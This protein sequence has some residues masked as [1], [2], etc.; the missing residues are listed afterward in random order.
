MAVIQRSGKVKTQ[1]SSPITLSLANPIDPAHSLVVLITS[2]SGASAQTFSG[3]CGG[4]ALAVATSGNHPNNVGA[5]AVLFLVDPLSGQS[6]VTVSAT[7]HAGY[8]TAA[9]LEVPKI[10]GAAP[11][12]RQSAITTATIASSGGDGTITPDAGTTTVAKALAVTLWGASGATATTLGSAAAPSGYDL[13]F[14]END[15]VNLQCGAGASS[16]LTSAQAVAPTW[17]VT[18]SAGA[19]QP[20]SLVG[21]TVVFELADQGGGTP[22]PDLSMGFS[23]I[24]PPDVLALSCSVLSAPAMRTLAAALLEAY[25]A[26]A[27]ACTVQSGGPINPVLSVQHAYKLWHGAGW[28]PSSVDVTVAAGESVLVLCAGWNSQGA[29]MVP[30]M[31]G[32]GLTAILDQGTNYGSYGYPVYCQ[33]YA[34]FGLSAG[35]Y[36]VSP[37]GYSTSADDGDMWVI[38]LAAG[39]SLRAGSA[40]QMHDEG[41]GFVSASL[42]LGAGAQIG[43]A[44]FGICVTDNWTTTTT[45]D[46]IEQT[47]WT[48][49]GRQ[50]NGSESAVNS[51]DWRPITAS[52]PSATWQWEDYDCRVRSAIVFALQVPQGGG[53]TLDAG[54]IDAPDLIAVSS[55]AQAAL[56]RSATE[57][58]DALSAQAASAS[59][60][61]AA[62]QEQ[63]DAPALSGTSALIAA[64]AATELPDAVAAALL[65]QASAVLDIALQEAA[66]A[67]GASA[68]TLS[69]AQALLAEAADGTTVAT[70]AALSASATLAEPLDALA[71]LLQAALGMAAASTEAQD[72]IDARLVPIVQ[73]AMYVDLAEAPDLL[74]LAA[75]AH[76]LAA[77]VLADGAD[78]LA[79][80]SATVAAMATALAE[81]ADATTAQLATEATAQMAVAV[82]EAPDTLVCAAQAAML[83]SAVLT[84]TDA[85][86]ASA[87]AAAIAN[88]A[89]VGS[90]DALAALLAQQPELATLDPRYIAT[91]A[92][93]AFLAVRTAR[94]YLAILRMGTTMSDELEEKDPAEPAE[95]SFSFDE[96]L[97]PGVTLTGATVIAVQP[98]G[99]IDHAAATWGAALTATVGVIDGEVGG[100]TLPAGRY[101]RVTVP[102]DTGISGLRYL[103][104]VQGATTDPDVAPVCKAILPVVR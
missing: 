79:S 10:S 56:G 51:I 45:L 83:A 68:T 36:T 14:S 22:P 100:R 12:N 102:A 25:D 86:Q 90:A 17:T 5:A 85:L 47:G 44:A 34:A 63:A 4:T 75:T 99:D 59:A 6:S 54:L 3:S 49:L 35:T 16:F 65:V 103:I 61:T 92:A 50:N 84:T 67:L 31:T 39:C 94:N 19:S 23:A 66:D 93:R 48:N 87:N 91:L 29:S 15:D 73:G 21:N 70:A 96:A 64:Y 53:L 32:P 2:Y 71:A 24:E 7:N 37:P 20:S 26:L 9:L 98:L 58:A 41:T 81:Q 55:I 33:T 76:S 28:V 18:A 77:A 52:S 104:A 78:A 27:M 95:L 1:G 69:A 72:A 11:I 80:T 13:E 62:A 8:Y 101:A 43:D 30:S 38:R 40:A 74:A 82:I 88:I 60:L 97:A 89:T 42:G 46:V 57:A